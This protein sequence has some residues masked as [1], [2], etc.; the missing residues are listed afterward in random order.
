MSDGATSIYRVSSATRD[1]DRLF[2]LRDALVELNRKN[3]DFGQ[4]QN[5][6]TTPDS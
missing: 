5:E 6:T 3:T 4:R 2:R 1:E